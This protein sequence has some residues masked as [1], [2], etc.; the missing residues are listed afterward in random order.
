[1]RPG[2]QSD[3]TL[4]LEGPQGIG[5][6]SAFRALMP[7]EEWYANTTAGVE[8]KDFKQNLLGIWLMGFDEL[9]SLTKAS[10]TKVKTELTNTRDHYRK[11]Y[12]RNPKGFPR[13]VGFCGS[14]NTE[15]YFNDPTGARRYLPTKVLR[16]IDVSRIVED[17]DQIWAEAYFRWKA[18]EAWHIDTP[19][20]LALCEEEQEERLELDAW[21]EPIKNWLSSDKISFKPIPK[22]ED[23]NK[24][25][26][27]DPFAHLRAAGVYDASKGVTT[28]DVLRI[29]IERPKERQTGGDVQRVAKILKRLGMERTRRRTGDEL[30]SKGKHTQEWRFSFPKS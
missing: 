5:K 14:T 23:S 24:D 17:R 16:K 29:V 26:A 20:L 19:E 7:R 1:M 2:C 27:K 21:E 22:A 9:D 30:D 18:G 8:E 10:L 15:V 4:I 25:A 3:C 6:T 13:T 11:S 12:G 28:G